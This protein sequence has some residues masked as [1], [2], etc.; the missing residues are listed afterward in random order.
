MRTRGAEAAAAGLFG[1]LFLGTIFFLIFIG[2][3]DFFFT[4]L[5]LVLDAYWL[6]TTWIICTVL[7]TLVISGIFLGKIKKN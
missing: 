3:V 1:G 6:M 2:I 7:C 4:K 5:Y